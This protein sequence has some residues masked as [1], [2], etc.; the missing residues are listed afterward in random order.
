MGP[1]CGTAIIDGVP[2]GLANAV[3]RGSIGVIG[4]SG[5]GMQAVTCLL[6]RSGIGISD[7]DRH[8]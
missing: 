4:A 1:D 5:T 3:P 7:G 2:L 6:A 8:G